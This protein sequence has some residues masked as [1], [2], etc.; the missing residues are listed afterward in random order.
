M[1]LAFWKRDWA[2]PKEE[3]CI[4]PENVWSNKGGWGVGGS[5]DAALTNNRYGPQ[6]A[7]APDLDDLDLLLM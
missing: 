7:R 4:A 1:P 2:L 5:G 6:S 3:S